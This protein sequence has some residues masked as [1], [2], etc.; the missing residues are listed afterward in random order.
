M[1]PETERLIRESWARFEPIAIQSARFFYSK[2]FELD[3]KAERLF[4]HTDWEAQ[5]R[6][7]MGMFAEIVRILDRPEDLVS[8]VADLGRRHVHYGVHESQY[9]SVGTALLWTLE[10]GLGEHFTP[11]TRD[12]WTEAYQLVSAIARRATTREHQAIS[13]EHQSVSGDREINP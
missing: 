12:A 9:D 4:T 10:Q 6:K 2:L 13:K 11:E 5:D 7:V 1:H 3:P 8:E